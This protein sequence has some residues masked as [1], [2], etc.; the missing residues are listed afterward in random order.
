MT[1]DPDR[2]AAV[3]RAH[4]AL[5]AGYLEMIEEMTCVA[6]GFR[7][8]M[9]ERLGGQGATHLRVLSALAESGMDGR[10]PGELAE[11]MQMPRA[12]LSRALGTL[13]AAGLIERGTW[14]GDARCASV[15]ITADGH[16]ARAGMIEA[17]AAE[18]ARVAGMTSLPLVAQ[19]TMAAQRMRKK[20]AIARAV[21]L[22]G[23]RRRPTR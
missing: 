18:L 6:D 12:S 23:P 11:R 22:R 8:L 4:P 3:P 7:R 17:L 13:E 5:T 2:P 10:A 9:V 15:W 14:R 1:R 19:A 21:R 20:Q 16:R